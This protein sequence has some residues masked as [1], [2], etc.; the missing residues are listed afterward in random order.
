MIFLVLILILFIGCNSS[1]DKQNVDAV[2]A[3]TFIKPVNSI[4]IEYNGLIC[5]KASIDN[6]KSSFILDSGAD[7]FCL[8]STFHYTS[9]KVKYNYKNFTVSGIGNSTQNVSYIMDS[10]LIS[11]SKNTSYFTRSVPVINLKSIGGDIVDG[12]IGTDF[13]ENRIIELNYEKE[14]IRVL[15]DINAIDISKHKKLEMKVINYRYYIPLTVKINDSITIKGDFMIDTGNPTSDFTSSVAD[16]FNLKKS[17]HHKVRY[18]SKYGGV[19]GESSGYD[20]IT[21]SVKISDYLFGGVIMSFSSDESGIMADE[22]YSG[23]VGNNILERFNVVFDFKKNNLYLKPNN[24]I[25]EP[26][27][28]EKLGFYYVDRCKTMGGWIVKGFYENSS[29]EK[30]GLLTDDKII[31]VNGTPVEKLSYKDQE[32]FFTNLDNVE[33]TVK[34]GESIKSIE[35]KLQPIL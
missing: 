33:L 3:S 14:Y 7:W 24:N 4:P 21:D 35:I 18:Y 1:N 12:L 26:F 28:P 5:I 22:E 30:Q 6:V 27:I 15:R 8:D 31:S 23:I 29:A 17:I 32:D 34:R 2:K 13:L 20:F 11:I 25:H 10:L 19:G 16:K 9:C